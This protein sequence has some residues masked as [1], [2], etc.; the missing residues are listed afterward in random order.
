M[1][2]IP[3]FLVILFFTIFE[4]SPQTSYSQ[5]TTSAAS[6]ARKITGYIAGHPIEKAYLQLDKPYYAAGDTIYF[7]AYV[8]DDYTHHLMNSGGVLTVDLIN[9]ADK[10]DQSI[11]LRIDSGLAHGDFALSDSLPSGDYRIRA[12]TQWM[13][14]NGQDDFFDKVIP[15]AGPKKDRLK[16]HVLLKP[17]LQFFP[18]GGAL[19]DGIPARIGFKALGPD[20]LGISVSGKVI[21]NAGDTVVT[22]KST[23]LGMGSFD[24]TPV[25]G[26]TYSA[27]AFYADG[28][29]D[30]VPLPAAG[31]SGIALSINNDS[32]AMARVQIIANTSYFQF[33]R[34]KVYTLLIR[35]GDLVT[36]LRCKLDTPVLQLGILK[37]KLHTGIAV[38]TLF[39]PDMEPLCE[40]LFFV[41]HYDNLD[42]D[43][44]SDKK[45]YGP[46]SKVSIHL[47]VLNRK[48]QPAAG[49]FSV[50]VTDET[51]VPDLRPYSDNIL[52]HLQLTSYLKGYIEQ[53]AYYFSD[54]SV[55][56]RKNLD[57]LL[58]TQ[59]YR[60]FKWQQ[61]LNSTSNP[62]AYQPEQGIT[63]AG[64]VRN[65]FN[66]P[67]AGGHI[68]LIPIKGGLLTAKA[69]DKGFFKFNNL[70]F[71]GPERFILSAINKKGKNTTKIVYYGPHW[72]EPKVLPEQEPAVNTDTLNPRY[73]NNEKTEQQNVAVYL[74]AR[75][76]MLKQVNIRERKLDDQYRTQS[77]AG[78]GFAD[79]VMHAKE[80]GQIQG[81][82]VNSLNG[83]LRG[84]QFIGPDFA[85][86]P[87]LTVNLWNTLGKHNQAAN[88]L[89]VIDG[90]YVDG[91]ALNSLD[92][93]EVETVEVLKYASASI[94]GEAG[95]G[96]V[97][98]ITTKKTMG[99][100]PDEIVSEGILPIT[101]PGFYKARVFYA[102]KYNNPGANDQRADLRSTIYW[103]P[104]LAT[105]KNGN[106]SF[107]YYNA[108]GKGVYKIIIEGIDDDGNIGRQV[109]RYKVQ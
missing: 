90:A 11:K 53:P 36:T 16:T 104:E 13:R 2:L 52:T 19:L 107:D 103:Q 77:F 9:T 93:D 57:N 73:L 34:D 85:K 64:Q 56:V 24:F 74:S 55:T 42:L 5:Q 70:V 61:V 29:S 3:Y 62:P 7:K 82:L 46:R 43:V 76:V 69:G 51:L 17:D 41:Q 89:V 63:I 81:P 26:R 58:L 15:V 45:S 49:H 4:C 71:A 68:S 59:G 23:H 86:I 102:P 6:Q 27:K 108:D 28:S 83:R 91:S 10:I 109:F 35:S 75:G 88:M 98:V 18:E 31:P 87:F 48:G 44:S 92:A 25:A 94:Y 79:Q 40:R 21:D 66:K 22:F 54:T 47:H 39:S 50:A 33:N 80:I 32:I 96:G 78:A 105:D 97:L 37:R 67:I 60:W 84:V 95:G 99:L 65:L 14:N 20:G 101:V 106:A 1:K 72:N 8:A 38:A 12:Y 30:T 100:T